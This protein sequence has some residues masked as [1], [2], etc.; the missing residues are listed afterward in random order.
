MDN[1]AFQL[2]V[3]FCFVFASICIDNYMSYGYNDVFIIALHF[4][5]GFANCIALHILYTYWSVLTRGR[6]VKYPNIRC[7]LTETQVFRD[8]ANVL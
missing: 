6:A 4:L 2:F 1:F 5:L 3:Y 8:V 7:E